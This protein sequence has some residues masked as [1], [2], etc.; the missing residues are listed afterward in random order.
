M[1][2][3]TKK[4][5]SFALA[6]TIVAG[7]PVAASAEN[8]NNKNETTIEETYD[9]TIEYVV[10]NG[11]TLGRIAELYYGN[12]GYWEQ[13][14]SYNHMKDPNELYIGQRILL[15]KTLPM[16]LDYVP[17][18]CNPTYVEPTTPTVNIYPEDTTYT[19][20]SGDTLYCIVRVLY[21][22]TNQEAVDKLATYNGLS[23]PNRISMGQVLLI[24]CIEKLN[25]VQQND[26][27]AEYNRMGWILN[28]PEGCK[29][30]PCDPCYVPTPC[31]PWPCA[32]GYMPWW[33]WQPE[34]PGHCP[35]LK[36]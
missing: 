8:N 4:L 32:P 25:Q 35:V 34:E 27:S 24:P 31:V 26:Y 21:G 7:V 19:V 28:H 16:I 9:D 23:D 30:K 13:L 29:P 11:D 22:L 12:A 10:K 3:S 36:P 15:P 20:K 33:G 5:L 6:G 1:K 17:Y 2:N 18:N 14:A